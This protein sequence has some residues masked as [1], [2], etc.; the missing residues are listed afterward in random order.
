MG[1]G[2]ALAL[3]LNTSTHEQLTWLCQ[4]EA[5]YLSTYPSNLQ[6]LLQLSTETG[7]RP[8]GMSHVVLPS[9]PVSP[10]LTQLAE[11]VWNC[12]C[13]ATYSANEVGLIASAIPGATEG[14]DVAAEN[15][16]VE[17][18]HEDGSPC[19]EGDVGRIV[20]TTLQDLRRP[21]LRYA[22]G[23]YGQWVPGDPTD[24][25]CLPRLRCIFGRE[26]TMIRLGDGHR[27]WPHFE[28]AGLIEQG[29]IRRWQLVQK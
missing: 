1:K 24:P 5:P 6:A 20:L 2:E 19:E 8:Q 26:R 3:T 15:V 27:I 22:I 4:V 12:A 16:Y 21:L 29:G 7:L 18:L 17:L 23:D 14:Y 28:F 13:L 9:E 25:I 11:K 10:E